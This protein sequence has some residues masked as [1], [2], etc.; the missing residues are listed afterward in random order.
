MMKPCVNLNWN[1]TLLD[2]TNYDFSTEQSN[3]QER[4][5]YRLQPWQKTTSILHKESKDQEQNSRWKPY[6]LKPPDSRTNSD[7]ADEEIQIRN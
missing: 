4:M 2:K 5:F 6:W 1:R 7:T 3:D